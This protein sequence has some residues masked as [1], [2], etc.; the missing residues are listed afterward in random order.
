MPVLPSLT[1]SEAV[2]FRVSAGIAN[3]WFASVFGCSQTAPAAHAVRCRNSRRFMEASERRRF[4]FFSTLDAK[5]L[6]PVSR[7][8]ANGGR[9]IRRPGRAAL[10]RLPKKLLE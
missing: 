6:P 8:Q 4:R 9:K 5:I 7:A 2:N 3:L 10:R 1:V